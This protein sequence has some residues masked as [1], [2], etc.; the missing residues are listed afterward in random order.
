MPTKLTPDPTKR[1][2]RKRRASERPRVGC[3][4]ELGG[5][6]LR[7]LPMLRPDFNSDEN[8]VDDVDVVRYGFCAGVNAC[9]CELG[10]VARIPQLDNRG[11]T[12]ATRI[13][14]KSAS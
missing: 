5:G 7:G 1:Q 10:F 4:E 9:E 3:C 11:G 13:L 14:V 12:W 6:G 8:G 2:A